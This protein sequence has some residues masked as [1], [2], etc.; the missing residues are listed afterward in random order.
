M[1][2]RSGRDRVSEGEGELV[3]ELR[4]WRGEVE[5]DRVRLVVGDDPARQIA[6][7]RRLCAL[8]GA[9]DASVV[10]DRPALMAK[11]R[12]IA[13]RKSSGLTGIPLEYLRPGR[14]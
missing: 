5:G 13:S 7:R 4:V 3:Q 1:I 10:G 6:A 9:D 2:G 14:R 11:T 12:S 8:G